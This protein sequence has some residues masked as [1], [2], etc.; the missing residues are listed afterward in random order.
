MHLV[1]L[2]SV[3]W[4][5]R[6]IAGPPRGIGSDFKPVNLGFLVGKKAMGQISPR[7]LDF[8][9]VIIF[10][11]MLC[12]HIWFVYDRRYIMFATDGVVQ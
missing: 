5:G 4:I 11:P 8:S 12:T 3:P 7:K 9:P 2:S 10:P 6:L 1:R